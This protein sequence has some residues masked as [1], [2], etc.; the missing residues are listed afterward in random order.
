MRTMNRLAVLA[1]AL[2]FSAAAGA[3]SLHE[4]TGMQAAS[5]GQLQLVVDGVGKGTADLRFGKFGTQD[6]AGTFD[7]GLVSAGRVNF[8][9]TFDGKTLSIKTNTGHTIRAQLEK[10]GDGQFD[11]KFTGDYSGTAKMTLK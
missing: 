7:S 5:R 4:I 1:F 10:T 2:A 6:V 3:Q 9:G 11:G 8:T